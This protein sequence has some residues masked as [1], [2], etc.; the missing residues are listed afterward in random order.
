M[1]DVSAS[2][3]FKVT[4]GKY[5]TVSGRSTQIEGVKADIGIPTE[6]SPYN[7]GERYLEYPL[8]NDRVPAVYVDLLTDVDQQA[9]IWLQKNYLPYIQKRESMWFQMVPQL[10]ANSSMRLKN[11]PNYQLFL[12]EISSSSR[13]DKKSNW[14]VKDLPMEEAVNVVKDMAAMSVK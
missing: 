14:G 11:D 4:V 6:Y 5:Y 2:A 1:T 7:I 8:S 3:F 9:K 12:K 13:A 10:Q